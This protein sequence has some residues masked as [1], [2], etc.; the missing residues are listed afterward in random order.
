MVKTIEE[1][2]GEEPDIV[3]KFNRSIL[4][5]AREHTQG[6]FDEEDD[7][8]ILMFDESARHGIYVPMAGGYHVI[9]N[10]ETYDVVGIYLEGWI[11]DY[12]SQIPVLQAMW[13]DASDSTMNGRTDAIVGSSKDA[14]ESFWATLLAYLLTLLV[15]PASEGKPG[16]LALAGAR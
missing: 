15:W 5:D 13:A 10:P 2:F 8:L 9:V 6:I 11:E 1:I 7:S 4:Q 12:V 16:E 3:P 14:Q